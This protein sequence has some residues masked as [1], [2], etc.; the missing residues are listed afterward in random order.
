MKEESF[1]KFQE[2]LELITRKWW[3]LVLFILIGTITPP[4]VTKGFAPSEAGE[5]ISHILQNSLIRFCSPL[6]PVFKIVPIVLVFTLFLFGNR[7]SRIFSFYGGITYLLFAFLQGIA[8]TDKYG[9]GMVTGNFI[10]MMLVAIFWFWEV[11]L[12]KND[13]SPQKPPLTRY[14]VIPLA[15]LAFWYP[16]NLESMEPDF[17]LTYLFIN[18]AGLAFCTMTP[19]YLSI[20]ILIIQRLISQHFEL[21]AFSE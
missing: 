11:F 13:F 12:G 18:P 16:V 9:F 2:K 10:L 6:Y 20:L 4:I 5:I 17:N 3:F 21:Q 15:F 1:G 7:V 8:I 14:W 19:V